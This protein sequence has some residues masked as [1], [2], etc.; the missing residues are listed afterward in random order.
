MKTMKKI[1]STCLGGAL[2]LGS[3]FSFTACAQ[4]KEII[5]A[6]DIAVKN[7]FV[8]TEAEWLLSLHGKNGTD[9]ESMNIYDLYEAAKNSENGY[10]GDILQFIQD[11]LNGEVYFLPDNNDTVSIAQNVSSAVSVYC[12]FR[13]KSNWYEQ[14][15]T[16][17]VGGAAGSG[18]II[19]YGFNKDAGTAYILTNYHVVY[20]SASA[21]ENGISDCIYL[22][23]YGARNYFTD[24]DVTGD[25]ILD[26]VNGDRK[27]DVND[28]GD[29]NGDGIRATYV[30]GAMDYDIAILKIEGSEYLKNSACQ[31]AV[32]GDS[33]ELKVGEKVYAVGNSNG[34][35]IS[36]TQGLVSVESENIEMAALD[37]RDTDGNQKVDPVSFRVLRTDAAIN[38]GNSGGGLYNAQGKLI[39]ITNAKSVEDETD[40]MGYA[41]PIT[42]VRYLVYNILDNV[43]LGVGKFATR[44]MLG[45]MT[46]I[47]KSISTMEDGAIKIKET[48]TLV[49]YGGTSTAA[50]DKL[51]IGDIFKSVTLK[52]PLDRTKTKT[53]EI[54][55]Q[56]EI[57]DLLWT[58]R[59][60]D[61]VT[62][63][64]LRDGVEKSVDI[65]FNKDAYFVKYA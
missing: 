47:E 21:T 38:H 37:G 62:F 15:R 50:K 34:Q 30:G 36:V 44:P 27:Y 12:A 28:Q 11:Y 58:V 60:G 51:L 53:V 4:E 39:G 19:D 8:G 63:T 35:G 65:T 33:N 41:L 59:K 29:Q 46:S 54:N 56:F 24:G 13:Q 42:Q 26:D 55:R 32:W 6:Y 10:E 57:N 23:P 64:V 3:A 17:K 18:L 43:A 5:N 7:G 9:G 2:L 61:T 49:D 16:P 45:V 52:D 1:L 22:Y 40:N 14:N 48:I 25:D 20:D 31:P